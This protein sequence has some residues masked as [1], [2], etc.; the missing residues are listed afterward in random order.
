MKEQIKICKQYLDLDLSSKLAGGCL[1]YKLVLDSLSK[2]IE[3]KDQ[4]DDSSLNKL[5]EI[6]LSINKANLD[7]KIRNIK[8]HGEK[9]LQKDLDE[10]EE[11]LNAR[12]KKYEE[13]RNFH[14]KLEE[15][16]DKIQEERNEMIKKYEEE[17][18][19]LIK[20]S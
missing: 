5:R 11:A 1:P 12:H 8:K 18:Q 17:R 20:D 9:S 6:F 7:I 10:A 14:N 2:A 13:R 3:L 19:K 16:S 15:K 4:T